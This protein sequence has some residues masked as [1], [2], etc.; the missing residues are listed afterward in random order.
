MTMG[1]SWLSSLIG[2]IASILARDHSLSTTGLASARMT[3]ACDGLIVL[4]NSPRVTPSADA[5]RSVEA[6]EGEACRSSTCE[7]KLG[8]NPHLSARVR[9]ERW[10]LLRR[11]RTISPTCIFFRSSVARLFRGAIFLVFFSTSSYLLVPARDSRAGCSMFG[12]L[13]QAGRLGTSV[14]SITVVAFQ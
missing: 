5:I 13:A 14:S 4:K 11:R 1:S 7:I 8:E 2:P 9:T 6:I 10:R 12:G 3:A